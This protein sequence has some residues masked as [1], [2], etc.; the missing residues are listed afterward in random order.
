[1]SILLAG[2]ALIGLLG[3]LV[4]RSETV[5]SRYR[6]SSVVDRDALEEAEREVRNLGLGHDPEDGFEGDDWGPGA[7]R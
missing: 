1:M 6:D 7:P 3:W 4:R 2:L 5:R